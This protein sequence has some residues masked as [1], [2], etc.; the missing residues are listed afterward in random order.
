M[1]IHSCS[2]LFFN[3]LGDP[4]QLCRPVV[5][6]KPYTIIQYNTKIGMYK[7][8]ID[9]DFQKERWF[10]SLFYGSSLNKE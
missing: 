2:N 3:I 7:Y 6:Y 5:S 4:V 9:N 8:R 1:N 10:T